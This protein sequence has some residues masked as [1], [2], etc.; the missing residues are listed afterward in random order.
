[1]K[2]GTPFLR[3]AIGTAIVAAVAGCSFSYSSESISGSIEGSSKSSSSSSPGEKETA[4]R[5]DVRDYTVAYV[6]SSEDSQAFFRGLGDLAKRHGVTAWESDRSTW[7]GIGEGLA[8]AK[9]SGAA[10]DAFK[11]SLAGASAAD[12]AAVQEGFDAYGAG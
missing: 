12:Q 9:V 5:D 8:R 2:Y 1:M 7:V 11:Q 3:A 4:Y 10:L 6:G